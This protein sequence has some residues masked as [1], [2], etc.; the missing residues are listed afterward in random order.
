MRTLGN[1][2]THQSSKQPKRNNVKLHP[3]AMDYNRT[4]KAEK[5][6]VEKQRND[7]QKGAQVAAGTTIASVAC[8]LA[9]GWFAGRML[10]SLL[11]GM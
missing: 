1:I 3:V 8:L 10:W 2:T 6:F 11:T 9:L 7:A 5:R 4:T